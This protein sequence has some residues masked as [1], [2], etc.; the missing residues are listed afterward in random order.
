MVDEEQ[1]VYCVNKLT[2]VKMINEEKSSGDFCSDLLH[3]YYKNSK[4]LNEFVRIAAS[5]VYNHC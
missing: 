1:L 4:G 2:V 5:V 3:N